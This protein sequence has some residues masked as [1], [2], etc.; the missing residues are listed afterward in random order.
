MNRTTWLMWVYRQ[1]L[2]GSLLMC[3]AIAAVV[4][5]VL[6]A[7][8][9]AIVLYLLDLVS[10][11]TA[12]VRDVLWGMF[13]EVE[14]LRKAGRWMGAGVRWGFSLSQARHEAVARLLLLDGL[15]LLTLMAWVLNKLLG[16]WVTLRVAGWFNRRY[17]ILRRSEYESLTAAARANK[18]TPPD[19]VLRLPDASGLPPMEELRAN[20]W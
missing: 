17:V 13:P 9:P 3:H 19:N 11:L 16:F 12:I 18:R 14:W 8:H 4:L 2:A 6:L 15:L 7:T 20:R 1:I 10:P 5:L